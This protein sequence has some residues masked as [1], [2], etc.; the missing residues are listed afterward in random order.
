MSERE[1]ERER[2]GERERE[3]EY[4]MRCK[5]YYDSTE[6]SAQDLL[7]GEVNE[8]ADWRWV[9]TFLSPGV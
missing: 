9:E 2:E 5:I 4:H 7:S 8:L 3:L 1:R 6:D